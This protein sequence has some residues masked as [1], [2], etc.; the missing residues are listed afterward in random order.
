[1][2]ASKISCEILSDLLS[3]GVKIAR[4]D[5]ID[6]DSTASLIKLGFKPLIF[7]IAG[8]YTITVQKDSVEAA[9]CEVRGGK[10]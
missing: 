4:I 1:M 6:L 2:I 3:I 7:K 8:L 5:G 9:L 10:R